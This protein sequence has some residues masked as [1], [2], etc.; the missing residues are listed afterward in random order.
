MGT[1]ANFF[2]LYT[3]TLVTELQVEWWEAA[4]EIFLA[5][6][7]LHGISISWAK[8][9]EIGAVVFSV[10][11]TQ[12]RAFIPWVRVCKTREHP[13]LVCNSW[14]LASATGTWGRMRNAEVLLKFARKWGNPVFLVTNRVDSPH[15]WAVKVQVTFLVQILQIQLS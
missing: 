11:R 8:T 1:M 12:D 10:H 3:H 15:C 7:S 14:D 4:V 2:L 6:F 13:P 9:K 5:C